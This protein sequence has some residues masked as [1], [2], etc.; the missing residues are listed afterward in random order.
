MSIIIDKAKEYLNLDISVIPAKE[1]KTPY[2]PPM[3]GWTQY[4]SKRLTENEV[5][6]F[7]SGKKGIA[8]ICGAISGNL[9]VIDV[10]TKYDITGSLWEDLSKLIEDNL[11][12]I[13]GSLVIAQTKSG[14]Y[15]IY[16]RCSKISGSLKLARRPLTQEEKTSNVNDK[17][18]VL[19]E[20][21]GEGGYVIAPPTAKYNYIQ[22]TPN[23]IPTITP[24]QRDVLFTIAKSFNEIH[25]ETSQ[26]T[27]IPIQ[28]K[29]ETTEKLSPFED[30]TQRGDVIGLL[31]SHGWKVVGGLNKQRI[32][33]LRPGQTDSKTSGNF[34]TGLRV[35]YIFS[36]STQFDNDRGY[37]AAQVFTLLECHGDNKLAY[38]RLLELGYGEPYK[39]EKI[40][41]TQVVTKVITVES[42]NRVTKEISVISKK[43]ETLKI[44][45]IQTAKGEEVVIK[46]PNSSATEE[47]LKAIELI[48]E[49]GKRIYVVENGVEIRGYKYNLNAI[50]TRYQ[51]FEAEQGELTDR[52]IDSLLNEIVQTAA[53]LNPLDKD[54]FIKDFLNLERIIELGIKEQ[55]IVDTV[56]RII[57]R[58]NKEELTIATQKLL[59]DANK[60]HD[61]GNSNEVLNV[62]SQKIKELRVIDKANSFGELLQPTSEAKLRDRLINKPESLATG[63]M[64]GEEELCLPYGALSILAA[65][66]SHG[67]TAFLINLAL[68]SAVTYKDKEFYLFSYEEDSDSILIKALNTYLDTPISGNN[69]TTISNYFIGKNHII[70][71]QGKDSFFSEL[72]KT[73]RLNINYCDY[74]TDTLIDAIRYL[75]KNTN[76]GGVFIDYMQLLNLPQGK[77][78]NFSRQEELKEVCLDLKNLA[79]ETGLPIVLGAQFNRQVLHHLRIHPTN[80]GEAG[81]IERAANLIVGFWNNS[82][83]IIGATEAEKSEIAGKRFN[84]PNTFYVKI[85]KQRNGKVGSEGLLQYDGNTGKIKNTNNMVLSKIPNPIQKDTD[86]FE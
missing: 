64:I 80:I 44:E 34:H 30:Y 12:E 1:D 51:Q 24:T 72:I 14:G 65:P 19:I 42:V 45:N 46:S 76:L 55:S 62:L 35:L 58:K 82:F 32:N 71:P 59:D 73:R 49:T 8:I 41:P 86:F 69:R 40:I 67:K 4:Q 39:G 18:R 81:D 9:E 77:H 68:N 57:E 11:P 26:E 61:S 70:L 79:V 83:E 38:R 33:L 23:T 27:K 75:N 20:T 17:L 52:D 5:N 43:G 56:D 50:Y 28:P 15:H 3:Q 74:D 29:H 54:Q 16:Y 63:Y 53:N 22:G 85:L 21:K 66:T 47:V 78:K 2:L 10:D 7:F 6:T 25:E 13:F 31:E 37:S 36:T 60:L 84:I 48:E